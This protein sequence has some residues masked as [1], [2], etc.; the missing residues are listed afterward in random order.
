MQQ[1]GKHGG[2]GVADGDVAALMMSQTGS[3]Q[4]R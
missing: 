4:G 1:P 2:K 3:L